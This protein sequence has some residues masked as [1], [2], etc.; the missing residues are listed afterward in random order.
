V[1]VHGFV[2]EWIIVARRAM[3]GNFKVRT[4]S[5]KGKGKAKEQV[6]G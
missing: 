4:E 1:F 2:S 5:G 3:E 6:S